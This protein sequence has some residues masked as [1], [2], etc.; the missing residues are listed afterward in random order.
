MAKN[1]QAVV[2]SPSHIPN[3]SP[4]YQLTIAHRS[5]SLSSTVITVPHCVSPSHRHGRYTVQPPIDFDSANLNVSSGLQKCESSHH[6]SF[7]W[8]H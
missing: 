7:E 5:S 6:L 3:R 2:C 4:S 8:N 1:K